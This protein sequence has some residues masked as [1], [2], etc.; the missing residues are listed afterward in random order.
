MNRLSKKKLLRWFIVCKI[1]YLRAG[2]REG[3]WLNDGSMMAQLWLIYGSTMV[4]L[5]LNY[6][7]TMAQLW[8]IYGSNN[9]VLLK[10]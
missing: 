8:L 9:E 1:I 2:F 10:C 7:S 4:H 6:G 5:W 3:L